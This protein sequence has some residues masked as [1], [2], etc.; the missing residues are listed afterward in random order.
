MTIQYVIVALV[1]LQRFWELF[2]ARR[3]TIA[4]RRAG[5]VEYGAGH[6]P[7]FVL[8]HASWL[9]ALLF[10]PMRGLSI[11]LLAVFVLLQTL[12]L[13][14]ILSL[15]GRWTTRILVVPGRPLIRHG[16]YRYLRHPN[17]LIVTGE[18]AILPL[19]F[20]LWELA[21][22]FSLLN[23]VLLACRVRTEDRALETA[24]AS[25]LGRG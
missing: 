11:M 14:V 2:Y 19:V 7:L 9:A 4:L 16:P 15:G 21:V 8:L 1:A 25:V 23:A 18:I 22:G 5:A 17:Y 10:W 24:S 13:W 12:R 3:N 6:Y 20:G